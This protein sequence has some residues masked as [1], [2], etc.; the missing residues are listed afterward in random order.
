MPVTVT[1]DSFALVDY[2]PAAIVAVAERLVGEV[3][4]PPDLAVVMSIDETTP[5]ARVTLTSLQPLELAVEGGALEDPKRIRQFSAARAADVI[6]MHLVQAR[7]R[8]DPAFAAPA[9]DESLT[10]AHQVAWDVYAVG[11]LERLGYPGQRQ[12]R[13]YQFRNRH[14][15]T[16]GADAAFERL[17]TAD[18]LTWAELTAISDEAAAQRV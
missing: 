16:D 4:L 13:L 2:D 9:V 1:P 17:W 12:R 3:G 14:G 10:L 15:F 11:R 6:G 7:D 18:G 5:L 8:L